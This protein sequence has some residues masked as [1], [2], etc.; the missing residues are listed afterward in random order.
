M[1]P[2]IFILFRISF[3]K[4]YYL[5]IVNYLIYDANDMPTI[6]FDYVSNPDVD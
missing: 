4:E 5:E 6:H 3:I 2:E 1:G